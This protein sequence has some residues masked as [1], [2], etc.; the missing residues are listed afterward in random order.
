MS[1][2]PR[3]QPDDDR[4]A[5]D[6]LLVQM[7]GQSAEALQLAE[8]WFDGDEDAAASLHRSLVQL[9]SVAGMVGLEGIGIL[10]GAAAKAAGAGNTVGREVLAEGLVALNA[11]LAALRPGDPAPVARYLEDINR[12]YAAAGVAPLDDEDSFIA[13]LAGVEPRWS[14]DAPQRKDGPTQQALAQKLREPAA[15]IFAALRRDAP[16]AAFDALSKLATNLERAAPDPASA[17]PWWLL[18]LLLAGRRD[19]T[20]SAAGLQAFLLDVEPLL[21]AVAEGRAPDEEWAQRAV[22]R[23]R[24]VTAVRAAYGL[25]SGQRDDGQVH[26]ARDA[27]GRAAQAELVRVRD[28]YDVYLRSGA[29]DAELLAPAAASLASIIAPLRVAGLVRVADL[30]EDARVALAALVEGQPLGPAANM[31]ADTLLHAE[32]MLESGNDRPAVKLRRESLAALVDVALQVLKDV[33]QAITAASEIDD[34]SGLGDGP[35]QLVG[36]AGAMKV[37]GLDNAAQ[38]ARQAADSLK[39]ARRGG[40]SLDSLAEAL[41]CFELHLGKVRQG[42]PDSGD[43]VDRAREALSG[44][45]A[46]AGPDT[47]A[48]GEPPVVS[49]S[50]DPDLLAIYIEEADEHLRAIVPQ[51]LELRLNPE[52]RDRRTGVQRFFHTLKGSGRMV[53]ALR[54]AEFC[55]AFEQLMARVNERDAPLTTPLL[56]LLGAALVATTQLREELASGTAP[57]APV[58]AIRAAAA[59]VAAIPPELVRSTLAA[60]VEAGASVVRRWLD[61]VRDG[62]SSGRVPPTVVDALGG[63]KEAS[64]ML[65]DEIVSVAAEE[66]HERLQGAFELDAAGAMELTEALER[67]TESVQAPKSGTSMDASTAESYRDEVRALLDQMGD[68]L[69]ALLLDAGDAD[70]VLS[71]QRNLHTLKGTSRVAGFSDLPDLTHEL[72]TVVQAVAQER[73]VVTPRLLWMLQRVFDAMFGMLD[74]DTPDMAATRARGLVQELSQ[75]AGDEDATAPLPA[76]AERRRKPRVSIESERVR[77]DQLDR[78]LVHALSLGLRTAE[79]DSRM[80]EQT[81]WSVAAVG[82]MLMALTGDAR[83]IRDALIRSRQAPVHLHASRWRR[84]VQQTAADAGRE[85]ELRFEGS[86]TEIDRRLLDGLVGPFEHLLRNAVVH[87]IESPFA[88]RAAGKPPAGTI[89]IRTILESEGVVVEIEDDGAGIDADKIRRAANERGLAVPEGKLGPD[90]LLQ[91]LATPGFSTASSVS[92]SA[93]FGIGLDSVLATI[94][95]LGGSVRLTTIPGAGSCF[96][97][98]VPNPS[99]V[100]PVELYRVGMALVAVPPSSVVTARSVEEGAAS[101]EFDGEQWPWLDVGA[102]IG[103]PRANADD[104]A[105][106]AV[107]LRHRNR[108]AAMRVNAVLGK[109]ETAVHRLQ[110]GELGDGKY[111]AGVGLLDAG[112][113]ATV[114][115]VEAALN[116]F[117]GALRLR[118]LAIVADD[119]PTARD[120]VVRKLEK[121]GWRVVAVEDGMSARQQLVRASP[122]VIVLDIDMPGLT[123]LEVLRWIRDQR[124]LVKTPVILASSA[125]DDARLEEARTLGAMA[126]LDKPF[127]GSAFEDVLASIPQSD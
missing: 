5:Q 105:A 86:D 80:Q 4:G 3:N 84:A 17:A 47:V 94:R 121:A 20:I 44:A 89:V 115:N 41:V 124:A 7:R 112:R 39:L 51:F 59:D 85:V 18:G 10:A 70:A 30:L 46:T 93:G 31:I 68:A 1:L 16:D 61:A 107:L 25:D 127:K 38:I 43:L 66:L 114:L 71:L 19:G 53:G 62:K 81:M 32:Q 40:Q 100:M 95:D 122:G 110:P 67:I 104:D 125:L 33:H 76:G 34:A 120:E 26:D 111:V 92:Q 74:D 99:P 36:V 60:T 52:D 98:N 103:A 14:A 72:E 123:G 106:I 88:R 69:D 24:T 75:R 118:P 97:L 82:E 55:W 45:V 37:A 29:G 42:A 79:I 50:A 102:A 96:I 23:L 15:K 27:L 87:G 91:V 54:I 117:E 8:R 116:D 22:Y 65:G 9:Q 90:A 11:H 73:M 64:S 126:C 58:G 13:R 6:A 49:P 109:A 113:L 77:A 108:G 63:L 56:G 12:L 83:A 2:P 78:A 119:S 21:A 101:V 35:G 57:S 28:I 48:E